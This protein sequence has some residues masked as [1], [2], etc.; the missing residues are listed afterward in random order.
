ML[1]SL[2]RILTMR[3][4]RWAAYP[5]TPRTSAATSPSR[6]A[7]LPRASADQACTS[8]RWEQAPRRSCHGQ[9][10]LSRL[11]SRRSTPH[12]PRNALHPSTCGGPSINRALHCHPERS[13]GSVWMGLEMLH[14][15]QH[16]RE[17]CLVTLSAAKGLSGWALRCFVALDLSEGPP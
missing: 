8:S 5:P 9:N 4:H 11:P 3:K 7:P 6:T 10:R 15:A 12:A 1:W 14:C 16:D 13:E 17:G 2:P